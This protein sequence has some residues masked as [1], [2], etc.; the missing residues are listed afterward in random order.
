MI[1]FLYNYIYVYLRDVVIKALPTLFLGSKVGLYLLGPGVCTSEPNL[2][3]L[4]LWDIENAGA[5]F[6]H[7]FFSELLR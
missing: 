2:L 6:K 1:F 7:I 4:S 3:F 5:L